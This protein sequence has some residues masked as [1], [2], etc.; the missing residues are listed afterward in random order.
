MHPMWGHGRNGPLPRV[1]AN[2]LSS[3]M[4]PFACCQTSQ[5]RALPR[6]RRG[7]GSLQR[8]GG[9][10]GPGRGLG[11]RRELTALGPRS[12]VAT[13]PGRGGRGRLRCAWARRVQ[14]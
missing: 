6:L 4:S 5:R 3:C 7:L 1:A 9:R 10:H 14:G 12:L 11:A 2:W 13:C 8:P